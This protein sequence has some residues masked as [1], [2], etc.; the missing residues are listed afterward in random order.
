MRTLSHVRV[1]VAGVLALMGAIAFSS[2]PVFAQI[3][4]SGILA[5]SDLVLS[6]EAGSGA[7]QHYSI[8]LS[9]R[10]GQ[11]V[12]TTNKDA[13]VARF[14]V[15]EA[16]ALALWQT[17]LENG[18]QTLPTAPAADTVP[19]S[20]EFIVKYRVLQT[21]GEF[22]AVGVDTLPEPR[23]RTIVRAIL[24]LASRYARMQG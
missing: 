22:S 21:A 2:P 5:D 17:V 7:Y 1:A 20:S 12:L 13:V 6:E 19:D 14:T 9:A 10:E 4:E 24:S 15:S 11:I 8:L 18:L 16:D 3:T 23:Y